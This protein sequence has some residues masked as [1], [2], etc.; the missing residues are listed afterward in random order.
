VLQLFSSLTDNQTALVGCVAA[1]G[2]ALSL[3]AVS[4]YAGQGT[5]SAV[6]VVKQAQTMERPERVGQRKAA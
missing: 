4:Y 2:G 6:R 3:L 1:L 5:K